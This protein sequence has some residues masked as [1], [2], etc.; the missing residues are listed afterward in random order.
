MDLEPSR[1]HAFVEMGQSD[2]GHRELSGVE[3]VHLMWRRSGGS[4]SHVESLNLQT[5]HWGGE[6]KLLLTDEKAIVIL[7]A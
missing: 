4:G 1:R 6:Q 7:K 2:T 5:V 3:R